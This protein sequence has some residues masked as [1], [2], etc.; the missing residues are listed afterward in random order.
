MKRISLTPDNYQQ[1]TELSP[2]ELLLIEGGSGFWEDLL[3]V[4]GMTAKCIYVF[5]KTAGEFQSSLS[6]SLKK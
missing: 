3:Y 1:V 2:E 6:P 5:G 4:V